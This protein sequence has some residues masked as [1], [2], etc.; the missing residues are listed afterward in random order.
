MNLQE[1]KMT[2]PEA[3]HSVMMRI[4]DSVPSLLFWAFW[5]YLLFI[6]N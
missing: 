2:W 5:F 1:S 3:F 4:I 6:Y